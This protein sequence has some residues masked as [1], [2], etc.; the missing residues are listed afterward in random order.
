MSNK[1][2]FSRLAI[3]FPA[4]FLCIPRSEEVVGAVLQAALARQH[5][6]LP[7]GTCHWGA[8]GPGQDGQKDNHQ[9]LS[10]LLRAVYQEIVRSLAKEI[11]NYARI[12]QNWNPKS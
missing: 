3:N 6:H 12:S 4:W 7:Q 8:G 11:S 2:P 5:S 1:S 10:S 9:I